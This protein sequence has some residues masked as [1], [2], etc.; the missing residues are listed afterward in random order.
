MHTACV[1]EAVTAR[2]PIKSRYR[3]VYTALCPGNSE[4]RNAVLGILGW[5]A[6]FTH[7]SV[8]SHALW[9]VMLF[10][11]AVP[12]PVFEDLYMEADKTAVIAAIQKVI[13]NG[14]T[15]GSPH[16]GAPA[17]KR[18]RDDIK[19]N[20]VDDNGCDDGGNDCDSAEVGAE[21]EEEHAALRKRVRIAC[22]CNTEP[23]CELDTID[24]EDEEDDDDYEDDYEDDH[25]DDHKDVTALEAPAAAP[26]VVPAVVL[27]A[28]DS[29]HSVGANAAVVSSGVQ[30][31]VVVLGDYGVDPCWH[32]Y[33][34]SGLA[35][36]VL[37]ARDDKKRLDMVLP[38][39]RRFIESPMLSSLTELEQLLRFAA[40]VAEDDCFGI[41][42]TLLQRLGPHPTPECN[43]LHVIPEEH[44]PRLLVE[45][46]EHPGP[47]AKAL[48]CYL[49]H[50]AQLSLM[51]GHARNV[52]AFSLKHASLF[53]RLCRQHG[54]AHP[55]I[56]SVCEDLLGRASVHVK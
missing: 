19:D 48:A 25:D 3:E 52:A 54:A 18:R 46:M 56:D 41:Y 38:H 20:S 12:T 34:L 31:E 24:E 47:D 16:S 51:E 30:Q 45:L 28:V 29:V 42:F 40:D 33:I 35:L 6:A 26:A 10:L 22:D 55:E 15:A 27:A 44:W 14:P 1:A 11:K 37:E 21:T 8:R 5:R 17:V 36:E 50:L 53:L 13:T 23:V 2:L 9:L 43:L 4:I 32:S 49:G 7:L 39:V